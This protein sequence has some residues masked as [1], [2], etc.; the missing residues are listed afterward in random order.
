MEHQ[1]CDHY[2][3][4]PQL[5]GQPREI[6][7]DADCQSWWQEMLDTLCNWWRDNLNEM[8]AQKNFRDADEIQNAI[9]CILNA[10]GGPTREGFTD[11]VITEV[12]NIFQ[13]LYRRAR[14]EGRMNHAE[15]YRGYV[16][17][18]YQRMTQWTQ[19]QNS[20]AWMTF[21]AQSLRGRSNGDAN[22]WSIVHAFEEECK[23]LRW[24]LMSLLRTDDTHKSRRQ[25]WKHFTPVGMNNMSR[26]W[27]PVA[28]AKVVRFP[29]FLC[30]ETSFKNHKETAN[31]ASDFQYV[32]PILKWQF[33]K[34][35]AG[36]EKIERCIC[37]PAVA[38]QNDRWKLW[39]PEHRIYNRS[40][41]FHQTNASQL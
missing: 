10:I 34:H 13:R 19:Q 31:Q 17:E 36:I 1:L 35:C 12:T 15:V 25:L 30:S 21:K 4:D 40:Q 16:D 7:G 20:R 2:E 39:L 11:R 33:Q 5:V 18:M 3:M 26:P 32:W 9:M 29:C 6:P 24:V 41:P 22:A 27:G 14:N 28:Q 8:S 38:T 37:S 23:H